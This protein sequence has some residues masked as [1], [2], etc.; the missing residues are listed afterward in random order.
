MDTLF[1]LSQ[2]TSTND[3]I[4]NFISSYNDDYV[5]VFTFNQTKGKG[6]YGNT[7]EAQPDKNL[8]YSLAIKLESIKL[9]DIL[10]NYYTASIL[11]DIIANLTSENAKIKWPNDIIL[12]NKKVSGM[13]IEKKKIL[14]KEYFVIGI[15]VNIL[16]ENFENLPKAGSIFSQTGK[17]LDMKNFAEYLHFQLYKKLSENIDEA[18]ILENFNQNLFKKDEVSVFEISKIRQNGIIRKA[19]KDG[20][21]WVELENLGLKKFFHKEIELLY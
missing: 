4:L 12:K 7:W 19:D 11:R 2:A 5:G 17:I 6:Q 18:S 13:L 15:G 16:Q 14:G 10:I 1:H 20:H 21:L 9:S 8:A 3:E